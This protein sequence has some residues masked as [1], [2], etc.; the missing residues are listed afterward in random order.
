[1]PLRFRRFHQLA[2]VLA[3]H[4]AVGVSHFERVRG[5]YQRA[6]YLWASGL[7]VVEFL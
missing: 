1:M 6:L 3:D 2:V 4:S 5:R 7:A